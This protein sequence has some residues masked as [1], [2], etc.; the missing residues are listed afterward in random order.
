MRRLPG[1]L[2]FVAL[3]IV[4]LDVPLLSIS[5]VV[6]MS[7]LVKTSLASRACYF[8]IM[9]VL[10]ISCITVVEVMLMMATNATVKR[11][12]RSDVHGVCVMSVIYL[13]YIAPQRAEYDSVII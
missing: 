11:I 4:P 12:W 13:L 1:R 5:I 7:A 3:L 9:L 8:D 10:Y 6:T 2:Q